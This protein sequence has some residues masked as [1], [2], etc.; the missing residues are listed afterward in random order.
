MTNEERIKILE[1]VA[2]GKLTVGQASQ[3]MD[4][5][6]MKSTTDAAKRPD[7][8]QRSGG[9]TQEAIGRIRGYRKSGDTVLTEAGLTNLPARQ[10]AALKN[11]GVDANYIRALQGAG[12]VADITVDQVI[13]LY[14]NGID[15]DYIRALQEAGLTD[16]T[17]KQVISLY[18]NGIDADY[19]RA[20]QE[21]GLIDLTAKQVISLYNN[22][23]DADDV[24][25][26]REVDVTGPTVER[27]LSWKEY[28]V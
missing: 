3:L 12:L 6:G 8:G 24:R 17:A 19:I 2:T 10:I 16:L 14:N 13:S 18:N 20:L 7:Q 27:L 22:G 26:L 23:V 25:A 15:A 9:Y 28:G 1:M 21:A 11:N 4:T 5:L